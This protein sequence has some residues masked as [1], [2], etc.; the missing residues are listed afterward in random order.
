MRSL[1]ILFVL[2][3]LACA[4]G[5]QVNT[6]MSFSS[7]FKDFDYSG[8][9]FR[10]SLSQLGSRRISGWECYG[11][12]VI[13]EHFIRLTPD[14]Q[15]KSGACWSNFMITEGSWVTTIK[16]RISGQVWKCYCNLI[17]G[18][19]SLW[20]WFFCVLYRSASVFWGIRLSVC[21]SIG[22]DVGSKWYVHW[23]CYWLFYFP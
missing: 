9:S 17:L 5:Y 7:P 10:T 21:W 20:R 2:S 12:A 3:T 18:C 22:K 14:R 8:M 13:N 6:Q 15:S 11:D 16:F 23:I 4:L 19:L 1:Y